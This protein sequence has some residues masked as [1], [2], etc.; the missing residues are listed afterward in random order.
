MDIDL[1]GF[2]SQCKYQ[3]MGGLIIHKGRCMTERETRVAVNYG[4]AMGYKSASEIPTERI[5]EICDTHGNAEWME[6][7]DDTPDFISMPELEQIIRKISNFWYNNFD[8]DDLIRQ[9]KEEYE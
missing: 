1:E 6:R 9:I 5:D 3:L 4:I 2:H 8:A 7:F